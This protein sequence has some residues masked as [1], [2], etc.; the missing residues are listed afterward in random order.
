VM[1]ID[2]DAIQARIIVALLVSVVF[3][4]MKLTIKP[5][6]RP[7]DSK[8][9]ALIE[10]SLI[11]IYVCILIIRTCQ[12]SGE[13]CKTFG[14]GSDANGVY[15]FFIFFGLGM[16]LFTLIISTV[17]LILAGYVP[18]ILLV[19]SAHGVPL[20]AIVRKVT[21]R[22][23]RA[24]WHKVSRVLRLD[25]PLV[26]VIT[27]AEVLR[28]RALGTG[29]PEARPAELPQAVMPVA[30][31][32]VVEL[33]IDGIFPPTTCFVRVD[34]KSFAIRW[35]RE[36]FISMHTV[37]DVERSIDWGSSTKPLAVYITFN[38]RGGISRVLELRMPADKAPAWVDGVRALLQAIPP[39][40]SPGHWRW[41]LACMA[42]TSD[43][44][45]TGFLRRSELRSVLVRANASARLSVAEVE[46]PLRLAKKEEQE[47][48]NWL[49]VPPEG[50]FRQGRS[51]NTKASE[52]LNVHQ[53][54]GMLQRL[55]TTT[56]ALTALFNKYAVDGRIGSAEWLRF[57]SDEQLRDGEAGVVDELVESQLST[58][59]EHFESASSTGPAGLD[60]LQ[61]ALQLLNSKNDAALPVREADAMHDLDEPLA[62]YWCATSHNSY[63]IGDQ[64]TGESSHEAYRRQLVQGCRH[65]EIDCWDGAVDPIV[66]HGNSF[67]TVEQFEEVASAVGDCAFVTTDLPVILSLEMHCSRN[68]Q[69]KLAKDLVK[70]LGEALFTY[71][72]LEATGRATMLSP[73]DFRSRV[74]LK[75]KVKTPKKKKRK[76]S[77]CLKRM[78][79]AVTS[80][81]SECGFHNRG[82]RRLSTASEKGDDQAAAGLV[83]YRPLHTWRKIT[84][85]RRS[86]TDSVDPRASAKLDDDDDDQIAEP[87]SQAMAAC[88]PATLS[89]LATTSGEGGGE[90]RRT[91]SRKVS[92]DA[93]A[94]DQA[95]TST[96]TTLAN[97]FTSP[98]GMRRSSADSKKIRTPTAGALAALAGAGDGDGD[99][100][101]TGSRKVSI[102]A[103]ALPEGAG[104]KR[105]PTFD[106]FKSPDLEN[107]SPAAHRRG[108]ALSDGGTCT[109]EDDLTCSERSSE[110]DDGMSDSSSEA[111]EDDA[112]MSDRSS[113]A[114]D[115]DDLDE[116]E[117]M[118]KARKT[119]RKREKR[120]ERPRSRKKTD[121]FYAG[122]LAL[123]SLPVGSF[124]G[125]APPQWVLPITSINED[126]ILKEMGVGEAER[127]QIEGLQLGMKVQ[128]A[129]SAAFNLTIAQL[130]MLAISRVA[131]SP[132]LDV[133]KLQRLS[134]KKLLRPFP[135]GLRTSG[136]N[137]SPLPF[138]LTGAQNVALNYSNVDVALQ[139]D[140]AL[141][142][143]SGGFVLKPPEMLRETLDVEARQSAIVPKVEPRRR[144]R[145]STLGCGRW[146][147][148]VAPR[149]KGWPLVRSQLSN[150]VQTSRAAIGDDVQY[151]SREDFWPPPR[152]ML[153]RTTIQFLSLHST[154]KRTEQ[155]PRFCGSR[156]KC[157][158]YAAQ[159]SG[160]FAP[161]DKRELSSPSLKLSLHPL[162]GFVGVSKIVPLQ[163]D[164][165]V[166]SIT[167]PAAKGNGINPAFSETVHCVAAEPHATFVRVSVFEGKQ[168]VA[169]ETCVLGRLQKGYRVLQMRNLLGTRIELFYAFVRITFGRERN[170]WQTSRQLRVAGYQH[171]Q[172]NIKLKKV[173]AAFEG[174]LRDNRDE[175]RAALLG[176]IRMPDSGNSTEMVASS[177]ADT[178]GKGKG[179]ASAEE[180]ADD[181]GVEHAGSSNPGTPSVGSAPPSC[182][183]TP[184][185]HEQREEKPKK[186][187]WNL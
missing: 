62:H 145:R 17:N 135:L 136:K 3:L 76:S 187:V 133:G 63:I 1:L 58:A 155:R 159:L 28:Y 128:S 95:Q 154:P 171:A 121:E 18:K 152:D 183:P 129:G 44:G 30:I 138:W 156:G 120:T 40:V 51:R 96:V 157:H 59:K 90:V 166:H 146:G 153:T 115:P 164:H 167:L 32:D 149:M 163:Q 55:S 124:L 99:V 7:D 64:L 179:I 178:G 14:F 31:G 9:S 38:D 141:F 19:A 91:G 119:L 160:T 140:F 49:V 175:S 85:K 147:S 65:V 177:P 22:R 173:I 20:S 150:I 161:P 165:E 151:E 82:S 26:T 92:I 89:S 101:R 48:P 6:K 16:L 110:Y 106:P 134:A 67:C 142:K 71:E 60:A 24:L 57:V 112:G 72:E 88:T 81:M 122:C 84:S 80:K 83:I 68:Q 100:R 176:H 182:S 10:L 4:T 186:D 77:A 170:M 33:R 69:R 109:D 97:F 132:P 73:L 66:W 12:Y 43:R 25:A 130:S 61:F 46:E 174:Q 105:R 39:S 104:T 118:A 168:E 5:L 23:V 126:R 86:S 37:E 158:A 94:A 29:H 125:S 116:V 114:G 34:L 180:A 52:L 75:G 2:E 56:K 148:S 137:M 50:S 41:A 117:A 47:L 36:R 144:S 54:A 108:S 162:G 8:L 70:Y 185:E 87:A 78:S 35:S 79:T 184:S 123:R 143:G 53:V 169:F 21:S 113:D 111:D 93:G 45:A 11:L 127:N 13:I 131:R 102:D 181:Q 107:A 172:E 103:G 98:T 42:A 15:I 27:A 139:V 74:L